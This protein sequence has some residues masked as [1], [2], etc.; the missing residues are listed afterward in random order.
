MEPSA[1]EAVQDALHVASLDPTR[2][3]EALSVLARFVAG[4]DAR[5]LGALA[6][7]EPP[8]G[9]WLLASTDEVEREYPREATELH[10]LFRAATGLPDG[11]VGPSEHFADGADLSRST[12]A[13]SHFGD[14]G[15]VHGVSAVIAA[16]PQ[17]SAVL[18]V[19]GRRSAGPWS[20]GA[21]ARLRATLG[22]VR[23][24]VAVYAA[25]RRARANAAVS[26]ALIDRL[27]LATLLVDRAGVI[28]R[29][30]QA[31]R[32]LLARGELCDASGRLRLDADGMGGALA[33]SLARCFD[34][35]GP[36]GGEVVIVPRD[37]RRPMLA[38][39]SALRVAGG[40]DPL[41]AVL[42]RDPEG[43]GNNA[44]DVLR[45]VFH[46]TARE[47]RLA[48]AIASGNTPDEA[49]ALL[50]MTVGT[51]R[52]HLKRVFYKT[53]TTRQAELV[54]LVLGEIPPTLE[55]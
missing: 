19:L 44:E 38:F 8:R 37:T 4:D 2:W 36:S 54:R 48:T 42:I 10:P 16:G 23:R 11:F 25:L 41:A 29:S 34:A 18:H 17:R 9:A 20:P 31:A 33:E 26:E 28:V 30:N 5:A 52:T 43:Q 7:A 14:G 49:A 46:L 6:L 39:V 40:A 45:E 53:A 51:A 22:P 24:A 3:S 13:R 27:D 35:T 1:P 47:A 12:L 32:A 50:G 21:D 55:P 15:S